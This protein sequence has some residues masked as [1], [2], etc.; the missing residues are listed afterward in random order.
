MH[1]I[2]CLSVSLYMGLESSSPTHIVFVFVFVFVVAA[3]H[4]TLQW[5]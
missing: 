3:R 5:W 4:V 1:Q 2:V